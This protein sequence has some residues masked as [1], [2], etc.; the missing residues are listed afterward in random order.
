MYNT[1]QEILKQIC[2]YIIANT[3]TGTSVCSFF[4]RPELLPSLI[5]QLTQAIP[6]PFKISHCHKCHATR[7]IMG[8]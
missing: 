2:D 7:H 3:N 8:R 5:H 6:Q 1:K 4:Y